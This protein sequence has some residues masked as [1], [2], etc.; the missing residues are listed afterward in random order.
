[1]Q[2]NPGHI[3]GGFGLDQ[4]ELDILR[5][6][7][8]LTGQIVENIPRME[9]VSSILRMRNLNYDGLG[10]PAD[11]PREEAL[12]LG[13]RVLKIATDYDDLEAAGVSPETAIE[14]LR[15]RKGTYDPRLLDALAKTVRERGVRPTREVDLTALEPGMVLAQ[16]LFSFEGVLLAPRGQEVTASLLHRLGNLA[17][18]TVREPISVMARP[19]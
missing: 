11:A 14:T 12:P 2:R 13:A 8:M 18:G 6:L 5:D 17:S 1:L 15:R 9:M 16:D 19:A 3:L 4:A 10:S 7:P